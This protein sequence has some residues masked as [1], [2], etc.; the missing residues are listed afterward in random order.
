MADA[1]LKV[2]QLRKVFPGRHGQAD[3]VA[4]DDVSFDL[5]EGESLAIVGES[6]S[7][8][9]TV[10]RTVV[11][12]EQPT[13]GRVLIAGRQ[14]AGNGNRSAERRRRAKEVQMVFQ[15]PY[16]SLDRRQSVQDGLLE[17]IDL[18][19]N[20]TDAERRGRLEELI[21]QVGFDARKAAAKPTALSGGER[22]RVSI[23]Q[24]LAARPQVLILDEAVAAL[25]VSI[26][27]QILNLLADIRA[28]TGVSYLFISHDLSVV[29]RISD[30]VVV[31]RSGKVI[32][33][34]PTATVFEEPADAYTRRL[35]DCIPRPGWKPSRRN[36]VVV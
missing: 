18:H 30:R 1:L 13:S 24:A 4:V 2:E 21:D 25:D 29:R 12:L 36:E 17:I 32:E 11:G 35:L 31:M 9:T 7:G 5:L 34:G 3:L 20:L 28:A 10:A 33:R 6:G 23:A 19:F 15:D 22:Q 16:L 14:R 26:Q 27:A 8:K